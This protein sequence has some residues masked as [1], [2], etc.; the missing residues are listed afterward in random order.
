[1][2]RCVALMETILWNTELNPLVALCN[3]KC[4]YP[5][6]SHTHKPKAETEINGCVWLGLHEHMIPKFSM[7]WQNATAPWNPGNWLDGPSA[8]SAPGAPGKRHSGGDL[9]PLLLLGLPSSSGSDFPRD[10]SVEDPVILA[11]SAVHAHECG[12]EL[13]TIQ[14]DHPELWMGQR[15]PVDYL[16]IVLSWE[17]AVCFF[18]TFWNDT[19]KII[20]RFMHQLN[21]S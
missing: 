4:W 17:N 8:H 11:A 12:H 20:Q 21:R 16:D 1:M 2:L 19:H 10:C 13:I 9:P 6:H 7:I 14:M 3:W 5:P 18:F 15:W